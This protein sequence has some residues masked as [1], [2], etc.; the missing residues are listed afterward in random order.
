MYVQYHR[1]LL[2]NASEFLLYDYTCYHFMYGSPSAFFFSGEHDK[3]ISFAGAAGLI[4]EKCLQSTTI[5]D[6]DGSESRK[7][8]HRPDLPAAVHD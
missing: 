6:A 2:S 1:I 8:I 7:G 4:Y 5:S 3:T